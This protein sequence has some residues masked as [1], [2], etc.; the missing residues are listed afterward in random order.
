MKKYLLELLKR[1]DLLI[2][3]VISGLKAEYRNTYLGYIWWILDP[4]LMAGVYYFLRVVVLGMKGDNI[5]AFLIIGLIAWHWIR[6]TL[7]G[8]ARSISGKAR[9]IT[10][11]YLPKAIFPIGVTLTQLINFSFGLIVVA[12]ALALYRI[13][14]NSEVLWLPFI[15]AVQFLFLIAIALVVAFLCMFVRDIDNVIGHF[16]KIWFWTSPVIY[17]HGRIPERYSYIM[18]YNPAATFLISY[19]NVLM[20]GISPQI[21]K[22]LIIGAVSFVVTMYMIYYYH[23]NEHKI[24][25]AL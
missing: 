23:V 11:V 24:I 21:E 5:G 22:L 19:R 6:S 10:Q 16:A 17:E 18:D 1:K 8:S 25:R 20:Y 3:L 13:V 14:P 12:I 15:M 7:T 4:L 2:Y 9:I